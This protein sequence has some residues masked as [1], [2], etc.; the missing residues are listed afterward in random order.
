MAKKESAQKLN[1]PD[2]FLE[3][4]KAITGKRPKTVIDHILQHGFITTEE[5][6]EKYGYD[7]PPST[8]R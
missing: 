5:L 7:H 6:N 1:L 3:R 2:E 8:L 4:L